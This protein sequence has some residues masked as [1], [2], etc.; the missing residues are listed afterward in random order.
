MLIDINSFNMQYLLFTFIIV[1]GVLAYNFFLD[2][3]RSFRI[4]KKIENKTQIT[5]D[6]CWNFHDRVALYIIRNF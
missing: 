5:Y 4:F 1:A 2:V 6:D 3:R